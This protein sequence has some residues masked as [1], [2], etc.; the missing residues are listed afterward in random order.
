MMFG[1]LICL[2]ALAQTQIPWE[3][4]QGPR[5]EKAVVVQE[6]YGKRILL[7]KAECPAYLAPAVSDGKQ[8]H[9]WRLVRDLGGKASW[10]KW[11]AGWE[12]AVYP[13][14]L[15]ETVF[16]DQRSLTAYAR[17]RPDLNPP[18]GGK[19]MVLAML[20]GVNKP[21][22]DEQRATKQ[23]FSSKVGLEPDDPPV[24][25]GQVP[26]E[27]AAGVFGVIAFLALIGTVL[28]LAKGK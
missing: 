5:G 10:R 9:E 1:T 13:K 27:V 25:A 19:D 4:A 26:I 14:V 12:D 16:P 24:M 21:N 28:Y 17:A 15:G 2:A 20:S 23:S 8:P 3:S 22:L 11:A 6:P 18:V 7:E